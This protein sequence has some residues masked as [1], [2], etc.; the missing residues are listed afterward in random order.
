MAQSTNVR[1]HELS[2]TQYKFILDESSSVIIDLNVYAGSMEY[3]LSNYHISNDKFDSHANETTHDGIV[4]HGK[5]NEGSYAFLNTNKLFEVGK[6]YYI[7]I[8]SLVSPSKAS[9]TI[10][11]EGN[12]IELSDAT[13]QK[14][15]MDKSHHLFYYYLQNTQEKMN[16]M[17]DTLPQDKFETYKVFAKLAKMD[18]DLFNNANSSNSSW[19]IEYSD[20]ISNPDYKI[21]Y[22][23]V[24]S[25]VLSI[26]FDFEDSSGNRQI[27]YI[28]VISTSSSLSSMDLIVS[29]SNYQ[30]LSLGTE[31][32]GNV[33]NVKDAM[34]LYTITVPTHYHHT[35]FLEVVPCY[36]EVDVTVYNSVKDLKSGLYQEKGT[37]LPSGKTYAILQNES[38]NSKSFLVS[39]Q[40]K[41]NMTD[42]T[43]QYEWSRFKI[44]YRRY[45]KEQAT[46]EFAEKYFVPN[47]GL[48]DWRIKNR[49]LH[50]WWPRII[51]DTGVNEVHHER[52]FYEVKIDYEPWEGFTQS[53]WNE[54]VNNFGDERLISYNAHNNYI[55]IDI[56]KIDPSKHKVYISVRAAIEEVSQDV[57]FYQTYY[58]VPYE[59]IKVTIKS[60]QYRQTPTFVWVVI[61]VALGLLSAGIIF[62]YVKYRTTKQKLDEE[63]KE[64]IREADIEPQSPGKSSI[65]ETNMDIKV[66]KYRKFKDEKED[67][68]D[69]VDNKKAIKQ[70]KKLDL[71]K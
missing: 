32:W 52:V 69:E 9:L 51:D 34:Q 2:Y 23:G 19:Q 17:I 61:V 40:S 46:N 42:G 7:I 27:L 38:E 48:L 53:C 66:T 60:S 26:D 1:F 65:M 56:E 43:I 24:R 13:P 14:V 6:T 35:Y 25:D 29:S 11:H 22:S 20:V 16:V 33:K 54:V 44:M 10:Y 4:H 3:I 49:I 68:D 36:G 57:S 64:I 12:Y 62:Y 58:R 21:D 41:N 45:T 18:N 39:V 67:E 71:E 37:K 47:N 31:K 28:V 30:T 8:K 15:I 55:D 63:V 50:V 5:V 59:A 70:V